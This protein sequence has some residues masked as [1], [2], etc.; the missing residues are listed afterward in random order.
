MNDPRP[1]L[2]V[3]DDEAA[4]RELLKAVLTDEGYEVFEAEGGQAAIA[5]L[6]AIPFDLV[7][8]DL[9]LE[10]TDGVSVLEQIRQRN[11]DLPA[12]MITAYATVP[13]A[14]S[15]MKLG[16]VD[17]LTKPVDLEE[18]KLVVARTLAGQSL[19]QQD[20]SAT[21][22]QA[23]QGFH[24]DIIGTS[25]TMRELGE[26]IQQVAP[27]EATVLI[28]GES[29]TGKELV[30]NA[31]HQLSHRADGPLV[32]VNCAALPENLLEAE[33][34]GHERGAFTDAI[35]QRKGRFELAHRGTI[36][37]DEVGEMSTA[38][39][40][41]L[42]RVLQ[43]QQFERVGGGQS[44]TVDVRVIAATNKDLRTEVEQGRFREDL[45]YRL[46]VFPILVPPLRKRKIDIPL[47]AIHFFQKYIEKNRRSL[48]GIAAIAME[49]LTRYNWPGNVRELE[50]AIERAVILAR[51]DEITVPDLPFE[52][53]KLQSEWNP[54][55][56]G[57]Q[58]GFSLKEVERE[59]IAKTLRQT[60]GNRTRAAEVL[61][62]ARRTL[63]YKLHEYGLE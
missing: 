40:A 54:S 27:T 38:T 48:R 44:I 32:K 23:N 53:Q 6:E 11:A 60:E 24:G 55:E 58:P 4:Q 43:E 16:A 9:R 34:F 51:G 62:I 50:N 3:V 30:A 26:M 19:K 2:L 7:I 15:A 59:L 20:S 5:A 47:L 45:F 37:L 8:L 21:E 31:I 61:G 12:L 25:D 36:F 42:L 56:I 17:Y 41:K 57:V 13:T 49:L 29:G 39:Q 46:N 52:V 10:D 1:K 14:V 33:L 18:L 63:Q 35:Q 28:Q 22:Q